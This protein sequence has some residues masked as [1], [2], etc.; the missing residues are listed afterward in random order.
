MLVLAS[1]SGAVLTVSVTRAPIIVNALR[2]LRFNLREVASCHNDDQHK[3]DEN[4]H[5]VEAE[6]AADLNLVRDTASVGALT[7]QAL[8]RALALVEV[9]FHSLQTDARTTGTVTK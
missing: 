6:L 4:D 8:S 9:L 7:T 1:I 2:L 3:E 5:D